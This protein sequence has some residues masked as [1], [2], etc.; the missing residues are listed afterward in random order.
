MEPRLGNFPCSSK[1]GLELLTDLF[2]HP[3]CWECSHAPT[4]FTS[5]TTENISSGLLCA[6]D[7]AGHQIDQMQ[8]NTVA[9]VDANRWSKQKRKT[10]D[11]PSQEHHGTP[12]GWC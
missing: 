8:E 1:D 11:K 5:L 7:G 6:R 12:T 3:E 4:H 9:D 10:E 2:L